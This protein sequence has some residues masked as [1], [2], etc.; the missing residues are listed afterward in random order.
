ML[1]RISP[2]RGE[3]WRVDLEPTR[4]AEMRKTRPAVVISSDSVSRLPLRLIVPFTDWNDSYADFLWMVRV[5]PEPGTGLTKT[6]AADA[7]QMRGVDLLRF[8]ERIGALPVVAINRIA[9]AIAFS[10]KYEPGT[11]DRQP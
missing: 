10:V 5:E 2:K 1:T 3:I 6:S 7:F 8:E 9:A 11:E 4:G